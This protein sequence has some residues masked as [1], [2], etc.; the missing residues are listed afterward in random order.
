MANFRP[1]N[2]VEWREYK[3]KLKKLQVEHVKTL[4]EREEE[5]KKMVGF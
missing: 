2:F 1:Q 4:K 5:E 3:D